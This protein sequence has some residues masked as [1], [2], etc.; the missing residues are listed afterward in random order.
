MVNTS[1][2][3]S[4]IPL[5]EKWVPLVPAARMAAFQ[6]WPFSDA[7]SFPPIE[8]VSTATTAFPPM[9]ASNEPLV[10]FS[11]PAAPENGVSHTPPPT[12]L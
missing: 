6:G 7:R 1:V 8:S 11:E 9:G 10:M 4:L 5:S 3:R 2:C 12:P